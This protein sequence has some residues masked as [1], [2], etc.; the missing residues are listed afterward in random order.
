MCKSIV[1][2]VEVEC[3]FNCAAGCMK[4]K[5]LSR[6]SRPLK[7]D[8][9][10]PNAPVAEEFEQFVKDTTNLTT[11]EYFKLLRRETNKTL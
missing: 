7:S 5:T 3:P 8:Y 10:E 6:N 1:E 11:L 2:G 4:E 9:P